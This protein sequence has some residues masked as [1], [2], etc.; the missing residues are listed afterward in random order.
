VSEASF[1]VLKEFSIGTDYRY[2]QD[3]ALLA[4]KHSLCLE[5]TEAAAPFISTPKQQ[6]DHDS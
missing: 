3:K 5:G 6:L 4:T 1:S 2:N